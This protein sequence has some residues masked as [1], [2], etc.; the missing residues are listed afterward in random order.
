M[1]RNQKPNLIKELVIFL[2]CR[3][4]LFLSHSVDMGHITEH[5]LCHNI[6][7]LNKSF[8]ISLKYQWFSI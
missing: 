5:F 2:V 8:H 7:I 6:N 1:Q 4:F 3:N